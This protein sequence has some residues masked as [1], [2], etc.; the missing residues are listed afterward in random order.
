MEKIIVVYGASNT[1]KTTTI[2][3]TYNKLM[4][5][6]AQVR[7]NPTFIDDSNDFEAVVEYK[8]KSIAINSLGDLRK[9]VDEVVRRY[10][11]YDILITALNEGFACVSADWLRNSNIICKVSKTVA[12]DTENNS[13]LKLIMSLIN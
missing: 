4:N 9:H 11:D 12:N 1:G 2:N 13:T 6:G 7:E 5:K 3:D 10:S 8:E